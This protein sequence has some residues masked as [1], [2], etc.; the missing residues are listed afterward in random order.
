MS[1]ELPTSGEPGVPRPSPADLPR[2]ALWPRGATRPFSGRR[3]GTAERPSRGQQVGAW[4]GT[5]LMVLGVVLLGLALVLPSW[6]A[7]AA[8]L[9]VGVV[10][11]GVAVRSRILE[12]VSV[13]D[14]S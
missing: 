6:P 2:P 14:P 9:A 8:G 13:S 5:A 1:E 4:V 3:D 12:D 10:G 11:V 7:A